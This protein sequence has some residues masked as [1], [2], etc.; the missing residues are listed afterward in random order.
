[1]MSC[2]RVRTLSSAFCV[3]AVVLGSALAVA[4]VRAEVVITEE[5]MHIG[6]GRLGFGNDANP[7]FALSHDVTVDGYSLPL[8]GTVEQLY[9]ANYTG[10]IDT[11]YYELNTTKA[12]LATTQASLASTQADLASTQ[13][14]LAS[15]DAERLLLQAQLET[16]HQQVGQMNPYNSP[17]VH[18]CSVGEP[19]PCTPVSPCARDQ[20]CLA[21]GKSDPC[22]A[23]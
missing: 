16:V 2:S 21:Q 10:R 17:L 3:V 22:N 20:Y 19:C 11:V 18:N 8:A 7:T 15:S 6:D 14:S 1:M 5:A 4:C 23:E 13:A 12:D 9:A